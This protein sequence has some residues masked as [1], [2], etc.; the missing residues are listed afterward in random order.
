MPH[1]KDLIQICLEP[2]AQICSMT[3]VML[4]QSTPISYDTEGFVKT[5]VVYTVTN[6]LNGQV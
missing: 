2:K 3:C 1:L 6:Y 4:S 5:G